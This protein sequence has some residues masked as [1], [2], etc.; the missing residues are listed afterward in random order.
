MPGP[1]TETPST[2]FAGL[3]GTSHLPVATENNRAWAN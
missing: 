3:D 2:G 1:A